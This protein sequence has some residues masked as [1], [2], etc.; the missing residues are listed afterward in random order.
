MLKPPVGSQ[1]QI[2]TGL[3]DRYVIPVVDIDRPALLGKQFVAAEMLLADRASGNINPSY[4]TGSPQILSGS[5][6]MPAINMIAALTKI[7]TSG[8]GTSIWP[9]S[10]KK[11]TVKTVRMIGHMGDCTVTVITGPMVKVIFHAVNDMLQ[12]IWDGEWIILDQLGC[13]LITSLEDPE[14]EE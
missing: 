9:D 10:T 4:P 12:M 13:T 8:V 11:G 3:T 14:V 7:N 1:R 6:D 2:L 5:G